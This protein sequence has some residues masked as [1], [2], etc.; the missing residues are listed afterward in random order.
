MADYYIEAICVNR[1]D[2]PRTSRF[3]AMATFVWA[4]FLSCVWGH[5]FLAQISRGP[6]LPAELLRPEHAMSGGV[7]FSV[8]LFFFGMWIQ[9]ISY[10]YYLNDPVQWSLHFM[11]TFVQKHYGFKLKMVLKWRCVGN[12][13]KSSMM[14][15]FKI[16]GNLKMEVLNC[17]DHCTLC[18]HYVFN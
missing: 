8:I 13:R 1:L 16:E 4:V 9:R 3:G 12:I 18:M 6:E 5:P 17:T 10:W 14:G 7:V 2:Q 11:T 15:C